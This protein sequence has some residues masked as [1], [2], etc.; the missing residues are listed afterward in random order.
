[1]EVGVEEEE[2]GRLVMPGNMT[3]VYLTLSCAYHTHTY[4]QY[5][6]AI[7]TFPGPPCILSK[8]T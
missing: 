4:T 3:L 8:N 2:D 1:V 5:I 6:V 7:A